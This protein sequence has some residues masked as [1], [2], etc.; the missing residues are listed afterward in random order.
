MTKADREALQKRIVNYYINNSERS[1]AA[2]WNFTCNYL[3]YI[4]KI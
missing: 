3:F 4:K 2:V 1:K